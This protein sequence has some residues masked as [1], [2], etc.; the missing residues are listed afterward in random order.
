MWSLLHYYT[1]YLPLNWNIVLVSLLHI[2]TIKQDNLQ[3]EGF[4]LAL[5]MGSMYLRRPL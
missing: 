5:N 1:V 2:D 4:I 3:E